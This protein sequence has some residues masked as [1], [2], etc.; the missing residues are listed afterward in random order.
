MPVAFALSMTIYAAYIMLTYYAMRF[1]NV[2]LEIVSPLAFATFTFIIAVIIKYLIKSRD[3]DAQYKLATTDGLTEL[4][5]H[6]YFQE[7]LQNQDRKS[8]V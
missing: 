7:Q 3:F 4:Y 5:N 8:V 6:R 1:S 2:W